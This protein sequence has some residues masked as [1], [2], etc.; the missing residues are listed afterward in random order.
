MRLLI[1][2][3]ACLALGA[4]S[5][6]P[7]QEAPKI[8]VDTTTGTASVPALNPLPTGNNG[9]DFIRIKLGNEFSLDDA[10]AYNA[11]TSVKDALGTTCTGD[12]MGLINAAKDAEAARGKAEL[13]RLHVIYDA[14]MLRNKLIGLQGTP[15]KPSAYMQS[16]LDCN[17]VIQDDVNRG[18][19]V[20]QEFK[21]L[22]ATLGGLAV[23]ADLK[24]FGAVL[25]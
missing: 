3:V 21:D 18:I 15:G 1:V 20:S 19:A 16:F 10:A 7:K 22:V 23:G 11:A 2:T 6:E 9:L 25:P 17:A 5:I 12:I 4:C 14:Q 24:I 13:G 8:V